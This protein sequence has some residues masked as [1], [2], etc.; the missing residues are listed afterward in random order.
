M[1]AYIYIVLESLCA[2]SMALLKISYGTYGHIDTSVRN[3]SSFYFYYCIVTS[4]IYSD[5]VLFKYSNFLIIA[6]KQNS[7]TYY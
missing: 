7:P 4:T 1:Y 5:V 6:K 2:N 3:W